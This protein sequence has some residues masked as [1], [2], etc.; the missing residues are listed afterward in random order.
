MREGKKG[1]RYRIQEGEEEGRGKGEEEEGGRTHGILCIAGSSREG[2]RKS[3]DCAQEA[4]GL[5]CVAAVEDWMGM[6]ASEFDFIA[7]TLTFISCNSKTK[8]FLFVFRLPPP[9][10]QPGLCQASSFTGGREV[11]VS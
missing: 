1:R 3:R 6:K 5:P 9:K 8:A 10:S 7:V 11:A 4:L 2:P